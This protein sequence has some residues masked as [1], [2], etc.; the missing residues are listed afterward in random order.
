MRPVLIFDNATVHTAKEKDALSVVYLNVGPG[1]VQPK[2]KDGWYHDEDGHKIVQ[3]MQFDNDQPKGMRQILEERGYRT[4]GMKK[5]D[6]QKAL[7]QEPDFEADKR[8]TILRDAVNRKNKYAV[9]MYSPKYH[10]DLNPKEMHWNSGKKRYGNQQDFNNTKKPQQIIKQIHN[11][12]D[13]IPIEEIE[14]HIHKSILYCEA[15]RGGATTK[16]VLQRVEQLKSVWQRK[17]KT[18]SS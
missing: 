12:L 11:C 1:G 4:R 13:A 8:H 2:M 17:R 16:D 6:L 14:N 10:C 3:K 15:Y 7:S 9:V 5:K 18:Y